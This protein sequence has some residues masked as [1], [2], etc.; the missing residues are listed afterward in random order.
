MEQPPEHEQVHLATARGQGWILLVEAAEPA[1]Q[2]G[3]AAQL[4]EVEQLREICLKIGEEVTSH[5]AIAARRAGSQ[6]GRESL[7]TGVKNLT[8]SKLGLLVAPRLWREILG[9]DQLGLQ[10]MTRRGQVAEQTA[11]NDQI[12]SA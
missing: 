4:G 10:R 9:D 7:D 12:D 2:M 5:A 11:E 1:E 3:I 8:K 6:N